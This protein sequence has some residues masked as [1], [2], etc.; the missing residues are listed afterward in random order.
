MAPAGSVLGGFVTIRLARNE[1]KEALESRVPP[2]KVNKV[3]EIFGRWGFGAIVIPAL[4]PPPVPM[5]PFLLAVGA[6]QYPA[7]RF[8]AAL[9][10]G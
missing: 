5:L 6:M 9:T 3:C 8:L 10:V 4:L 7:R 2:R 1:G